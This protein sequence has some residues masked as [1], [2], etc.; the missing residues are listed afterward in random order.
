MQIVENK[1]TKTY[2]VLCITFLLERFRDF[3]IVK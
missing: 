3:K 1:Y 2:T